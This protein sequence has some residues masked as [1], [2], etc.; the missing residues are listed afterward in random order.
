MNDYLLNYYLPG[1]AKTV[2]IEL[3]VAVLFGLWSLR[4]LR[5]VVLVNLATHPALH[6][7]LWA[8]FWSQ[9]VREPLPVQLALEVTVFLAEGAMLRWWLRLPAGRMFVLS[10]MMNAASYLIGLALL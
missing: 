5:A 8:L 1:F 3:G 6:G 9:G 10:A 7:V 4:Q 2:A